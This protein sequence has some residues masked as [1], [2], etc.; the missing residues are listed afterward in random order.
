MRLSTNFQQTAMETK[1]TGVFLVDGEN[2]SIA[3]HV[4]TINHSHPNVVENTESLV[5][6]DPFMF[7]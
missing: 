3:I 1:K 6:L 4:K 5:F 2:N 7:R